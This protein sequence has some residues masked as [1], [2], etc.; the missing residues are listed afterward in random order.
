MYRSLLLLAAFALACSGGEK[1]KA[2]GAEVAPGITIEH[3]AEGTGASP[4][5]TD[6]VVVH[7]EGRFQD[8][9]V[10]DSS[11]QSGQPARFPLNGVISCWTQAIQQMKVGGKAK[12]TC[13]PEVAYGATGMGPIPPNSTLIFDVELIGIEGQ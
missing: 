13:A 1:P 7:Y 4:K 8:G 11:I 2:G 9:R 6:V 10:F 12:L 5:A 3:T